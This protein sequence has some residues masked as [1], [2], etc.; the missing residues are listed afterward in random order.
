[1]L[2]ENKRATS[3]VLDSVSRRRIGGSGS[4]EWKVYFWYEDVL[5][6]F[7]CGAFMCLP[8]DDKS[9]PVRSV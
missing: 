2:M 9:D 7:V 3:E 4:G 6:P 1:M 8:I 5:L